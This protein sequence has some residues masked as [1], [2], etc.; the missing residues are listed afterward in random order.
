MAINQN[1]ALFSLI[2]TYYGGNGTTTFQLPDLRSRVAVHIG[3]GNGLSPYNIG[4]AGG[5]ENVPIT[6]NNLAAHNHNVSLQASDATA[7][8]TRPGGAVLARTSAAIYTAGS[9]GTV[10]KSQPTSNTGSNVPISVIEPYLAI[11]YCICTV[12]IFPSRN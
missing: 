10:M 8:A 2:G 9:D 11:N 4:Q 1:T 7:D 6:L 12:G 5:S 3:Q